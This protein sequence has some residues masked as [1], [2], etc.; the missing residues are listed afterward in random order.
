[1]A[2][3]AAAFASSHSVMLTCELEDWL[4]RFRESDQRMPF[5][6]REG[7]SCGYAD[8]L[9]RARPDAAGLVTP[10][11]ITR[12]FNATQDAMERLKH[13]IQAARLDVLIV[14]GDNL[15]LANSSKIAR[16]VRKAKLPAMSPVREFMGDGILV[17]YGPSMK[18]AG[19]M[20]AV[21]VHKILTGAKPGDLPIEEISKLDF[22][23][24]LRVAR[25]LGLKVPQELLFRADEVIR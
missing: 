17:S 4:T 23:I 20:T 25:E 9:A 22:I 3:I 8:M 12:T 16:A 18:E 15:F 10:E 7:K 19:R 1:M 24:D 11:A 21:Y 14:L 13:E 6:D 5:Y 2:R